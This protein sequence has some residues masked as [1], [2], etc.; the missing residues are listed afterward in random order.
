MTTKVIALPRPTQT[1]SPLPWLFV[2]LVLLVV[3]AVLLGNMVLTQSA[4]Q[5]APKFNPQRGELTGTV[6]GGTAVLTWYTGGYNNQ[7]H[8]QVDFR[9]AITGNMMQAD[10]NPCNP[11]QLADGLKFMKNMMAQTGHL[12]D[13]MAEG[14]DQLIQMLSAM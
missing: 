7:C 11:K 3:V 13:W 12:T 10:D 4:A 1:S 9:G 5:T 14:L 2:G 8:Y 6:A